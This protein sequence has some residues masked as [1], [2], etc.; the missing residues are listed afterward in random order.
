MKLSK[1]GDTFRFEF[2]HE[3]IIPLAEPVSEKNEIPVRSQG[4]SANQLRQ[5]CM[6]VISFLH[7]LT[8]KT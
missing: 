4:R 1:L 5:M 7:V 2:A 3:T 6:L 8:N